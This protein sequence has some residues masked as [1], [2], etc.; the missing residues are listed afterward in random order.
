MGQKI[1][2]FSPDGK[3]VMVDTDDLDRA[4]IGEGRAKAY[5]RDRYDPKIMA[6]SLP[7]STTDPDTIEILR[8]LDLP[9]P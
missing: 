1:E 7:L 3:P 6:I 8:K 2:L 9:D 5:R 4:K